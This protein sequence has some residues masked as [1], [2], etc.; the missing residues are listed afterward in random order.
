MDREFFR[1]QQSQ[2][3]GGLEQE[4]EQERRRLS[5]VGQHFTFYKKGEQA[6]ALQY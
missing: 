3:C 6:Q 2:G 5:V 4:E 1:R